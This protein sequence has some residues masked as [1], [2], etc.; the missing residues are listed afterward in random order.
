M[1][2]LK[3][4][5][6]SLRTDVT[7]SKAKTEYIARSCDTHSFRPPLYTLLRLHITSTHTLADSQ[8]SMPSHHSFP[9]KSLRP[10]WFS[11]QVP[12]ALVA[13]DICLFETPT[14]SKLQQNPF[15]FWYHQN[16]SL[17]RIHSLLI[18]FAHPPFQRA[19]QHLDATSHILTPGDRPLRRSLR[20][21]PVLL[22]M[23]FQTALLS[24]AWDLRV[25][26]YGLLGSERQGDGFGVRR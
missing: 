6:E 8:C 23:H 17:D 25:D 24:L 11:F 22:L 2:H 18:F 5:N 19:R 7:V 20:R 1:S 15:P 12:V 4:H 14:R 16:A 10:F 9:C 3:M 13:V 21:L 26:I